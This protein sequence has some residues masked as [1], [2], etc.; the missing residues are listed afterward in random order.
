MPIAVLIW[1]IVAPSGVAGTIFLLS[2]APWRRSKVTTNEQA[3]A[4]GRWAVGPAIA[5]GYV[6]GQT[7]LVGWQPIG[8]DITQWLI[9]LALAAAAVG[10][11]EVSLT[12]PRL[13]RWPLRFGF[14]FG[15][16]Y[17]LL[18]P[19]IVNGNV[20]PM[21]VLALAAGIVLL[22]TVID[23]LAA[24][25]RGP[26]LALYL[27]LLCGGIA[28]TV[29]FSGNATTAMLSGALV[30]TLGA[31]WVLTL[32]WPAPARLRS[33]A[34]VVAAVAV[35][36]LVVG[37]FYT[38]SMPP[39]S[40]LLLLGAPLVLL[41]AHLALRH[42][43]WS[44]ALLGRLVALAAPVAVAAGLAATTYFAPSSVVNPPGERAT[45]PAESSKKA[46]P[47]APKTTWEDDY[48]Y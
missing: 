7:G 21:W 37:R 38:D 10:S 23:V 29:L 11:V 43:S 32:K 45:T 39:L 18:R 27:A 40:F 9:Y 46:A 13:A 25:D 24:E 34:P 2:I 20:R 26:T 35:G 15:A 42:K 48:G 47:K 6:L 8:G 14:G 12:L 31:A 3:P 30:S 4:A 16:A 22:W 36:Q 19:L 17:L 33:A 28:A 44:L 1:A 41:V 5:G